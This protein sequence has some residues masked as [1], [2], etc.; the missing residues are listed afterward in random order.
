MQLIEHHRQIHDP[1]GHKEREYIFQRLMCDGYVACH[2][3]YREEVVQD[4]EPTFFEDAIGHTCWEKAMDE[5][6]AMLDK[7]LVAQSRATRLSSKA[8][9]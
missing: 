1:P 2:Y 7:S 6:M 9:P 5:E 3:A 8:K 4:V